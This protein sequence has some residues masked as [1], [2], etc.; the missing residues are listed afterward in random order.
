MKFYLSCII[1]LFLNSEIRAQ[2]NTEKIF[3]SDIYHFWEA[4]DQIRATEDSA[5][6]YKLLKE[7]YFDKGS[8]GLAAIRQARRYSDK[9][10]I[11]AINNHPLF[12]KSIRPNTLKAKDYAAEISQGLEGLKEIYPDLKPAH[13]YFTIG[14]FR[15]PGTT[16]D[17]LVLIG[18]ELA[19]TN[20]ETLTTEFSPRFSYLRNYFDSEP[21]KEIVF[22]NIHEYVH[23]QQIFD[24]GYDLLTFCLY[25]GIAEFMAVKASGKTSPTPAIAFGKENDAWVKEVFSKEMFSY[26][27]DRWLWNNFENEF[28][29]R[30][31]G[32]YMGYAIAEKYYEEADDKQ[33]AVKELIELKFTDKEVVWN[34]VDGTK[35]FDKPLA[36]YEADYESRRPTVTKLLSFENGNQEVDPNTTEIAVTFSHEMLPGYYSTGFGEKGRDYLPEITGVRFTED[37]KGAIYEVK[38]EPGKEYQFMVGMGFRLP[39]GVQLKPYEISFRTKSL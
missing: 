34:F 20:K 33:A 31:L 13:I 12:W 3:T 27:N 15:T 17:S 7:L 26:Y 11:D 19:M 35:Y 38:L 23:T 6:Q 29:M 21:I 36:E 8:P 37:N 32:Y 16:M 5:E 9:D 10:Y 30:D 4:Y 1:L 28:K 14:A 2:A 25:E 24:Y 18:S 22:L 39:N